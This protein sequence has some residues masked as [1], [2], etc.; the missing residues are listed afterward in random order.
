VTE[1]RNFQALSPDS[2]QS[3]FVDLASGE[4]LSNSE[5]FHSIFDGSDTVV[6]Q[7]CIAQGDVS[8]WGRMFITAVPLS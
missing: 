7:T 4:K 6:L 2:T 3:S 5:L 1:I 8:T